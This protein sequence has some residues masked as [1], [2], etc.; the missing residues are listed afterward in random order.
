MRCGVVKQCL[1]RCISVVIVNFSSRRKNF[2]FW[3]DLNRLGNND[4]SNQGSKYQCLNTAN[5]FAF[6]LSFGWLYVG[7]HTLGSTM[8][9]LRCSQCSAIY[10]WKTY[11]FK[12]CLLVSYSPTS[13]ILT[14]STPNCEAVLNE[15]S[16][17]YKLTW[18]IL[19]F[20]F[21]FTRTTLSRVQTAKPPN[22]RVDKNHRDHMYEEMEATKVGFSFDVAASGQ[23][24]SKS[25]HTHDSEYF[26]L[27]RLSIGDWTN[28][29]M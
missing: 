13:Q 18:F 11:A 24:F 4:W 28:Q 23:R 12:L 17:S 19:G 22:W 14:K 25:R 15:F 9:W 16:T 8:Y 21:K 1:K 10:T 2:G 3:V 7:S 29:L 6:Q 5:K 20:C 26:V 27:N